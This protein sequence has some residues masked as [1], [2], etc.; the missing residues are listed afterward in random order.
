MLKRF[1]YAF[2]DGVSGSRSMPC[3]S[4]LGVV[5]TAPVESSALWGT[6]IHGVREAKITDYLQPMTRLVDYGVAILIANKFDCGAWP[7][8]SR[9]LTKSTD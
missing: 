8:L 9:L 6:G 4:T 3:A 2:V 7:P 1:Y 5:L